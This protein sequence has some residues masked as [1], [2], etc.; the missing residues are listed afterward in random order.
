MSGRGILLGQAAPTAFAMTDIAGC[1][2]WVKADQ[3]GGLSDG[4]PV[5]TWS[6]QSGNSN[7]LTRAGSNRPTYKTGIQNG[8][9]IVRFAPA[10]AQ[11]MIKSSFSSLSGSDVPWSAL[12]VAKCDSVAATRTAFGIGRAA[13]NTPLHRLSWGTTNYQVQRRDDANSSVTVGGGTSDTS[14]HVIAVL[15]S[16][17]TCT[18]IKDGTVLANATAQNVG[19]TT[20]DRLAVGALEG[21]SQ[22]NPFSGDI[23]E[24]GLFDSLLDGS[25]YERAGHALAY[26]WDIAGSW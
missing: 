19:T 8:L 7:D 10:S 24:F 14:W 12:I 18:I 13:S 25:E 22:S 15:F 11:S 20:L 21:S 23:A 6:D 1:L 5:S 17:T 26:K 2:C 9:P 4:D 3:I 16:G